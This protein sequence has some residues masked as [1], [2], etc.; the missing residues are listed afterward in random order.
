MSEA[1]TAR[2]EKSEP[3]LA[4][5][6]AY[7]VDV[8][9]IW[10]T[11]CSSASAAFHSSFRVLEQHTGGG[12]ARHFEIAMSSICHLRRFFVTKSARMGVGSTSMKK[13]D[14]VVVLFGGGTPYILRKRKTEWLFVGD[15]FVDGFMNGEAIDEWQA[16]RVEKQCFEIV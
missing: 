3:R 15:Y 16:G 8:Y 5:F 13:G 12:E 9:S 11:K 7:M 10:R 2:I 4:N 6:C 14:A 1:T